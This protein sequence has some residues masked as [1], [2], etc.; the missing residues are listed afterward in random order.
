MPW[1]CSCGFEHENGHKYSGHFTHHRGPEHQKVGWVDPESGDTFE[2]KP[3]EG[4]VVNTHL[5][6]NPAKTESKDPIQ[7]IGITGKPIMLDLGSETVPF[8]RGKIYDAYQ[9]YVDMKAKGLI[10]KDDFA[11]VCRDGVGLIWRILSNNPVF[12][13]E[14]VEAMEVSNAG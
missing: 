1:K 14:K 12:E 13:T 4:A 5:P 9:L 6:A 3:R 11:D 7:T 8:D 2:K 10:V